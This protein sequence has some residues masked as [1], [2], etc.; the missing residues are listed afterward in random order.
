[1][2]DRKFYLLDECP[3]CGG[4]LREAGFTN[5]NTRILSCIKCGKIMLESDIEK[6]R[7]ERNDEKEEEEI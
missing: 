2:V 6:I 4:D 5:N 3:Y 7:E 1:M